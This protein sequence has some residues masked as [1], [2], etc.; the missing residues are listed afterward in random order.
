MRLLLDA[1]V[2]FTAAHNP[3]GRAM[4]LFL[5]ARLGRCTLLSSPH[6][7]EEARRNLLVKYPEKFAAFGQLVLEVTVVSE[8]TAEEI[9][10]AT[11]QALPEKDAPI[12]AAAVQARVD[13]LV[14][15]DRTHFGH[16]YGKVL[17]GVEVVKPA[18][19]LARVMAE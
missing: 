6:A 15:G 10:W 4:G 5:L 11:E 19:A 17:R 8:A 2:I 14:T 18:Q 7:L 9:A 3:D 1:N 16:L 13:L 12:L